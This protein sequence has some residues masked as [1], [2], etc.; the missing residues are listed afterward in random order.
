MLTGAGVGNAEQGAEVMSRV[1]A[2]ADQPKRI[3]V[4]LVQINNNYGNQYYLPYSVGALTA[5]VQND[6]ELSK[7][8]ELRDFVFKRDYVD[9]IVRAVGR[10]DVLGVSCYVWNWRL[11]VEVAKGVRANNPDAVIIFGGPQIPDHDEL[12][13]DKYP[14]VDLVV[15]G[16]SLSQH[17]KHFIRDFDTGVFSIGNDQHFLFRAGN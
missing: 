4:Q 17:H 2:F 11:S 10:V 12:F 14:F 1:S 13:F 3:S 6:T 5:F 7:Y 16:I 8:I 9:D 15:H